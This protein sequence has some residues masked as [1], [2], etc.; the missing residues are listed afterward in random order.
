MKKILF[1]A[2]SL[3]CIFFAAGCNGNTVASTSTNAPAASSSKNNNNTPGASK[4]AQ[5]QTEKNAQTSASS[6]QISMDEAKKIA[7]ENAGVQETDA[8]Y[9]NAK[10]DYDD[11]KTTYD[12]EFYCGN[13][14]YDY[15]IYA[16]TGAVLSYDHDIENDPAASAFSSGEVKIDLDA[17]KA[18]ALKQAGLS[19]EDVTMKEAKLEYDD[20]KAVYQ[21]EFFHAQTEYDYKIDA[22][23]ATVLEFDTES[24]YD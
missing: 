3:F 15:E 19:A 6:A 23:N 9:V 20:G 8:V 5:P 7:L 2:L 1:I 17:A 13:T 24:I 18:A 10:L 11:G 16:F 4:T 12:V 22:N 14:Q 21:I